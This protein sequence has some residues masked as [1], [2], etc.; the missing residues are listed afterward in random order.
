MCRTQFEL[1][2]AAEADVICNGRHQ[3]RSEDQ[4][5]ESVG[6]VGEISDQTH[7]FL[8]NPQKSSLL[9]VR[10]PRWINF[11]YATFD[12]HHGMRHHRPQHRRPNPFG[13]HRNCDLT[14]PAKPPSDGLPHCLTERPSS[15]T[16][17]VL[18]VP[19][20]VLQED[21][22]MSNAPRRTKPLHSPIRGSVARHPPPEPWDDQALLDLPYDNPFYSRAIDNSLWLPRDPT[23]LLDLDDTIDLKSSITVD[24]SAGRLGSWIAVD[25]TTSPEEVSIASRSIVTRFPVDLQEVDGTE[26]IDLPPVIARRVNS[27]EKDVE[28]VSHHRR[29]LIPRRVSSEQKSL[30]GSEKRVPGRRPSILDLPTTPYHTLTSASIMSARRP[31]SGSLMSILQ[32]SQQPVF[33]ESSSVDGNLPLDTEAQAVSIAANANAHA[34]PKALQSQNIPAA[35]AI[36]HEV[37]EEERE[38]L[39]DLVE[40]EAA[41]GN[42]ETKGRKSWLISWLYW[43]SD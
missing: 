42:T 39:Q 40:Q 34:P 14:E 12:R 17:G 2:D 38:A 33:V 5:P 18:M 3:Q 21:P 28:R 24:E 11:S 25:E 26:E 35:Q 15:P 23:G 4:D 7:D 30:G 32:M 37:L 13:P 16:N 8:T 43:R 9:T 31:R 27:N 41:E 19:R 10:F 29:P 36:F 6:L 22:A 20:E 1:D